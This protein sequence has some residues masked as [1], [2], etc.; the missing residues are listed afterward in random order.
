MSF[1]RSFGFPDTRPRAP[2]TAASSDKAAALGVLPEWNLADLYPAMGSPRFTADLARAEAECKRFAETYKGKLAA[3]AEADGG[4]GLMEAVKHYEA[5]DDLMGRIMS[6][7]GLLYYGNTSD[8]V[9][10]KFFG[11]TQEKINSPGDPLIAREICMA[12]GQADAKALPPPVI[13]GQDHISSSGKLVYTALQVQK[14][15]PCLSKKN[16]APRAIRAVPAA[17]SSI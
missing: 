8:P 2:Q 1:V 5:L 12:C 15:T 9:L 13:C 3:L 17:R 6:Y 10:A 16:F 4:K 11:D 7:A 14:T